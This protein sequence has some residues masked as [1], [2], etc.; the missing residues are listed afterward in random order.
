VICLYY[1]DTWGRR[2]TLWI[3]GLIMA[4]DMGLVMG[5]S[6]GYGSSQNMVAKGFT[7]AFIFCFTAM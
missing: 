1:V 5:L 7:I 3:T 2:K 6:G 4:L